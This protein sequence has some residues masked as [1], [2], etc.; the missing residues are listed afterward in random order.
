MLRKKDF[1]SQTISKLPNYQFTK[2]K[3]KFLATFCLF[4]LIA[5]QTGCWVT[6]DEGTIQVQTIYGKISRIIRASDGGVWT[7]WTIGDDY[8]RVNLRA[9]TDEVDITASSKDNAALT[10]KVAVTYHVLDTDENIMSYVRKFGLDDKERAERLGQIL[11]GQVNTE[12]K[13]SLAN[14]DA[15]SLLANQE[16]IQKELQEK[17][18]PLFRQQLFIELESVQIIGRPDFLDD[19]IEQAASQVVANQKLKE[20]SQAALE[21]AKIDA[22]KKQVEAQTYANPALLEIRKLELQKE[23]AEAWSK[24]QGTLVLGDTKS[25]I[26]L[27]SKK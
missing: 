14:F 21:A 3:N 19:R 16:Q 9:K 1:G 25:L 17:L 18:K 6:T 2:M 13:N 26:Q 23:I 12:T 10:M 8:Y 4:L 24:H 5:T 7:I 22:E 15:Y 11:R 27:D 20:A